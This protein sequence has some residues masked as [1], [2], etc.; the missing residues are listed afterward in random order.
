MRI[1][2]ETRR[3]VRRLFERLDY[4][5]LGPIYCY[6][7]GDEFWRAK[8]EPCRKL[9]F[10]LAEALLKKLPRGGRSLYVGAGVAELPCLL[11]ETMDLHRHVEPYNLRRIE[12]A[13]LNR[14]CRGTPLRFRART[15]EGAKAP[16]DHLWI[17]SVLND[18]ERFPD[19][20]SLSYGNANPVTFRPAQFVRQRRTVQSIVNRCMA[21]LSLPALVTTSIEE[22][23]WIADWCHRHRVPYHVE[24]KYYATALV[25]DPV[26][27]IRVGTLQTKFPIRQTPSA[28]RGDSYT[29]GHSARSSQ[30]ILGSTPLPCP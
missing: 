30:P 16:F 24:R 15:A 25:G 4:Q 3:T 22:V 26:C 11:A 17:V 2:L 18:P 20:S 9:G 27:F 28:L 19:L 5:R 21:K 1:S 29:C 14:A 13:V 8:C 12:V 10:K 7:G 6:E 23:V